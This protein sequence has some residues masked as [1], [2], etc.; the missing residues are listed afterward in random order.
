LLSEDTYPP[1]PEG[2]Q[3]Y[4][5]WS[6]DGFIVI[7]QDAANGTHSAAWI[8]DRIVEDADDTWEFDDP[9]KDEGFRKHLA[10][11]IY[12]VEQGQEDAYLEST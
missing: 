10:E 11:V 4:V 9:I 2:G 5:S 7:S 1:L 8:R 6:G 3:G 12:S